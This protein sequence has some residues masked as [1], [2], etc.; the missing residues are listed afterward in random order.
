MTTKVK[1]PSLQMNSFFFHYDLLL[2]IAFKEL[3]I[4][5]KVVHLTAGRYQFNELWIS[6]CFPWGK[7]IASCFIDCHL[8]LPL[9]VSW[10]L[11]FNDTAQ[12]FAKMTLIIYLVWAERK[13]SKPDVWHISHQV[14]SNAIRDYSQCI[15]W[16]ITGFI[17]GFTSFEEVGH[18]QGTSGVPTATWNWLN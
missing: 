17:H 18:Q 15:Y 5:L 8:R 14:D 6:M 16:W 12:K 7:D 1:F 11:I 10:R 2:S 3:W 9:T 13:L 4:G